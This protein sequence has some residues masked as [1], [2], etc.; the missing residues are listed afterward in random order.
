MR[1]AL[2]PRQK[3]F[4]AAI[5]KEN[6]LCA[7]SLGVEAGSTRQDHSNI[8][9]WFSLVRE[10]C[11]PVQAVCDF[12]KAAGETNPT[13]V[14]LNGLLSHTESTEWFDYLQ[15]ESKG[16][17]QK[18]SQ[19]FSDMAPREVGSRWRTCA[20]EHVFDDP[21]PDE[22]PQEAVIRGDLLRQR[23]DFRGVVLATLCRF[24]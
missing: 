18:G 19:P 10:G 21:V 2:K 7:L 5:S 13:A 3:A 6:S 4:V 23:A 11:P 9:E 24:V 20:S 22:A 17:L 12:Y 16:A 15:T 1:E 14:R 8:T